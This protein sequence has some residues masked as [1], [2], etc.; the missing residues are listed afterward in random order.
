MIRKV[1]R[2]YDESYGNICHSDRSE[3]RSKASAPFEIA[4]ECFKECEVG[5]PLHVLEFGEIYYF[6]S[7]Y[8]CRISYNGEYSRNNITCND[9]YYKRNKLHHLLSENGTDYDRE[10]RHKSTYKANKRVRIH[11]ESTV[12]VFRSTH[13]VSDCIARKRKTYYSNRRSYNNR[14]HYFVYPFCSGKL[15]NYGYY[16]IYESRKERSEYKPDITCGN[17]YAARKSRE[18]R[19]KERKGRA[20]ENRAFEFREQQIYYCSHTCSEE[21]GGLRHCRFGIDAVY[22]RRNSDRGSKDR[23]KL[24]ECKDKHL[25][26][27]RLIFYTVDKFH[28]FFL[29]TFFYLVPF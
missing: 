29:L 25:T 11:Y 5:I 2:K 4:L 23:E 20:E 19:R 8:A 15:N 24:L 9:S 18:H 7:L 14:R 12:C 21:R 26:E 6:K 17:R 1:F 22:N 10:E 13:S 27:L 3:I 16:D 28:M